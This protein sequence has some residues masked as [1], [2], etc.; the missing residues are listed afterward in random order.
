[1]LPA[2]MRSRLVPYLLIVG[3]TRKARYRALCSTHVNSGPVGYFTV[4]G[5][6]IQTCVPAASCGAIKAERG[7][8]CP[9][10]RPAVNDNPYYFADKTRRPT[11]FPSRVASRR[12]IS[13]RSI[14]TCRRQP[15]PKRERERRVPSA[16][17][18]VYGLLICTS[19]TN[20]RASRVRAEPGMLDGTEPCFFAPTSALRHHP[21][22]DKKRS[23]GTKKRLPNE[24]GLRNVDSSSAFT[25]P[26]RPSRNDIIR[27]RA[28]NSAGP[29]RGGGVQ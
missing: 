16:D 2:F 1:M 24:M 21:F 23:A 22:A 20:T 3:G 27:R 17:P 9:Q 5:H 29:P 28:E 14:K 7:P 8:R 4:I 19:V 26:A 18:I 13:R 11:E 15:H 12:S 6:R 25:L 10:T